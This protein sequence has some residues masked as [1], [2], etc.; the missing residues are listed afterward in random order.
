MKQ[1]FIGLYHCP[2]GISWHKQMGY[3][4]RTPDM[5]FALERRKVG[6]KMKQCPV[7]RFKSESTSK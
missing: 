4:R 5:I 2:C 3:F 6:K 7:I 1:Q